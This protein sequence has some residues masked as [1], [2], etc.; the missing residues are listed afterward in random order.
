MKVSPAFFRGES[1]QRLLKRAAA[2]SALPVSL[3]YHGHDESELHIMGWNSCAVCAKV[4][5]THAGALACRDSRARAAT[6]ALRQ[7][8]PITFVCHLGFTCVSVAALPDNGYVLT[9]GPYIPAE[10][11]Q[12]IIYDVARGLNEIEGEVKGKEELPFAISDVRTIPS[13]SVSAAAEWL[14]ESLRALAS[15]YLQ[16]EEELV[17]ENENAAR[18]TDA[19]AKQKTAVSGAEPN[20]WISLA[21]LALLCGRSAIVHNML[22]GRLHE[23]TS[24]RDCHADTLHSFLV[25]AISQLLE[26]A[27]QMGA[28]TER[29]WTNYAC[30]TTA[31]H[32]LTEPAQMLKAAMRVLRTVRMNDNRRMPSYLPELVDIVHRKYRDDLKLAPLA[33]EFGVAASSVTRAL[34]CRINATFTGY[35]GRVRIEQARRLLR[36][37][38]LTATQ[39]GPRVGIHDQSNFGKMFHRYAGM[40][41]GA[42][43]SR[44]QEKRKTKQ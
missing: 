16:D 43:R 35:L 15:T 42:Y 40:T 39:I 23:L 4:S 8:A 36:T 27:R 12:E 31:V 9:F 11:N 19:D 38:T 26:A 1:A 32:S 29:A 33:K 13:G 21:A 14:V 30:F 17:F 2:A 7:N 18:I 41:P 25:Q 3:H 6:H 5:G 10:A 34:E 20:T 44:Y 28:V 24:L 22:S 37:T